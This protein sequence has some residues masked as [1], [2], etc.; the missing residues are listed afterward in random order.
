MGE[1]PGDVTPNRVMVSP[2]LEEPLP[3]PLPMA[4]RA[5]GRGAEYVSPLLSEEGMGEERSHRIAVIAYRSSII[6]ASRIAE[7]LWSQGE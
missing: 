5:I 2:S 3:P 4:L 6:P 7:V 1:E